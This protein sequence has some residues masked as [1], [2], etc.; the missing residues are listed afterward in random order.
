MKNTYK[1]LSDNLK[2][3]HDLEDGVGKR[4]IL[5]IGCEGV[6]WIHVAQD[7]VQWL[8]LIKGMACTLTE[9]RH[10]DVLGKWKYS[11]TH[12]LPRH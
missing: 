3:R 5:K 10:E 1:T 2:T 8:A 6:D 11:S 9:H 4:I 12:F 7:M